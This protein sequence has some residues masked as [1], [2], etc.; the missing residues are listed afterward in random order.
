[1]AFWS[2][3]CDTFHLVNM[4]LLWCEHNGILVYFLWHFSPCERE[5]MVW[6]QCHFGPLLVTL[7]T[8]WTWSYYGV[9]TMAFWSTS[10]DT[11]HLV[12]MKLLWCE[13]VH[14]LCHFSPCEHGVM[15]WTQWHFGSLLVTL[16][17][18][19]TWSYGVNMM[20]LWFTFCDT[21]HLVNIKLLCEHNGILDHFLWHFTLWIWRYYGVNMVALWYT[22]CKHDVIKVWTQW[23][24][25]SFLGTLS[26]VR[27]IRV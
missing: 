21:F 2:T 17:T 18:L 8:L 3:F 19:W 1:M 10:C 5:F 24:F 20:A 15:V 4:K 12:N 6:T 11:F 27:V 16:F 13:L 9:N 26:Q 7:F 14:F 23:H 22:F 25:R